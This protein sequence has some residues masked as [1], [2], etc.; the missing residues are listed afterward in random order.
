MYGPDSVILIFIS[1]SLLTC[2]MGF[3]S[4][5]QSPGVLRTGSPSQNTPLF[6]SKCASWSIVPV[7]E[8]FSNRENSASF[9]I[10]DLLLFF[11]IGERGLSLIKQQEERMRRHVLQL[12]CRAKGLI[13]EGHLTGWRLLTD[14]TASARACSWFFFS[15]KPMPIR[16]HRWGEYLPIIQKSRAL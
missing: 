1:V 12:P 15:H 7:L 10:P 4:K 3:K 16:R 6:L 2:V 13:A 5:P 11:R 9:S 8:A 14:T